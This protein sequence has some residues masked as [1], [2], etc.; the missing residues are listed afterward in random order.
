ML[1]LFMTGLSKNV[2]YIF[3]HI[4]GVRSYRYGPTAV[5]LSVGTRDVIFRPGGE[6]E[7]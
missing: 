3:R 6:A 4:Y 1:L 2:D 7:G 5:F